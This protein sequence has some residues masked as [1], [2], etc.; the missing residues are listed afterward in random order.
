MKQ[1]LFDVVLVVLKFFWKAKLY[2]GK[3]KKKGEGSIGAVKEDMKI[4]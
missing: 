2:I 4:N 3:R 1:L